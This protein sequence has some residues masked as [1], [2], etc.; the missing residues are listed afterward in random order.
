MAK[1]A[2]SDSA[3]TR[4]FNDIIGIVLMGSAILLLIAL[5][6][7]DAHDVAQN[8][9]ETNH[10]ARNWIGPIGAHIAYYCLLWVGVS[11]FVLPF[12]LVFLGL[13]CF[14][15]QLAYVRRRWVW[16]AVLFGCC[17]GLFDLYRGL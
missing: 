2:A 11:A 12:I 9:T 6:S 5:L 15:E 8:S 13:G 3:S 7:Y 10:P 4:G 17:M 14:F 16:T 1:K